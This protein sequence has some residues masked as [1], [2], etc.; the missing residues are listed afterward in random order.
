M[1]RFP[2]YLLIYVQNITRIAMILQSKGYR[3]LLSVTSLSDTKLCIFLDPSGLYVRLQE[4]SDIQLGF[5]KSKSS[6]D[7]KNGRLG[8]FCIPTTEASSTAT[9][10]SSTFAWSKTELTTDPK[11]EELIYLQRKNPTKK[12]TKE[13]KSENDAELEILKQQQ[14]DDWMKSNS[15]DGSILQS[16]KMATKKE[17]EYLDPKTFEEHDGF[18]VVDSEDVIIG[19]SRTVFIWLGHKP[20]TS[21]F[22]LCLCERMDAGDIR[23]KIDIANVRKQSALLCIGFSCTNFEGAIDKVKRKIK[24]ELIDEKQYVPGFGVIQKCKDSINMID[25]EVFCKKEDYE[26]QAKRGDRLL[27]VIRKDQKA[28]TNEESEKRIEY[29]VNAKHLRGMA[30][31]LSEGAIDPVKDKPQDKQAQQSDSS[32]E[33]E[34][35]KEKTFKKVPRYLYASANL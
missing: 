26:K 1:I 22:T 27:E 5:N 25:I 4:L 12:T 11:K 29:Q 14:M 10:F 24:A 18:K 6:K 28:P 13:S 35:G 31:Y 8:Y 32:E 34:E 21:S 16:M 20:R 9:F 23:S 19:L 15:I 3:C 2:E 33:E 17:K 30:K 7:A